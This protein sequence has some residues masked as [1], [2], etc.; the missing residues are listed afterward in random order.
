MSIKQIETERLVLIPMSYPMIRSLLNDDNSELVKLGVTCGDGWP[1]QDT[2][3]IM[4]FLMKNL[5]EGQESSG[6][7]AW[8]IVKKEALVVIGDAGFT[9]PPDNDGGVET[10]YGLIEHER[11]KGYGYEAV[12]ALVDWAMTQE[13]VKRICAEALANNDASIHLL[14]K[15]GMEEKRRDEE[16]AYFEIVK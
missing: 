4:R 7:D 16:S 9:G 5:K 2:Y 11:K 15:L 3:D 10:G 1:R 13:N 8:L 6:F 12:K 14:E